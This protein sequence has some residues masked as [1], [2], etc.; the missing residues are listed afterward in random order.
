M[1]G[2][3]V[4]GV[5]GFRV[6]GV[7]FLDIITEAGVARVQLYLCFGRSTG[8]T[9]QSGKIFNLFEEYGWMGGQ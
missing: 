2:V 4:F 5:Y 3:A 8:L 7:L 9:P 1:C 6:R